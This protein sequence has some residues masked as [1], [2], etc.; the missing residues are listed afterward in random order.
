MIFHFF[1]AQNHVENIL[2]WEYNKCVVCNL[3]AQGRIINN[4]RNI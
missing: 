2:V 1:G 4:H 3:E